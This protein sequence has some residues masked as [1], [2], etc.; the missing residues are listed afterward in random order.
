MEG[1]GGLAISP[2]HKMA[3]KEGEGKKLFTWFMDIK[4]QGLFSFII[5]FPKMKLQLKAEH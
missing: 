4:P 3:H 5:G 2:Y 1:I